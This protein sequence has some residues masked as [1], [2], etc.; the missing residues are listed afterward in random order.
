MLAVVIEKQSHQNSVYRQVKNP[1]PTFVIPKK[2]G[3]NAEKPTLPFNRKLMEKAEGFTSRFDF[4]MHVAVAR[5]LGKRFR[6]PPVLRLRAIEALLQ[7]LC[8]HY[9]PLANRANATLTTIAIECGLATESKKGNLAIT[10]ATRALQSLAKD[11]GF[12]TYSDKAFDPTIGCNLPTDITFTPAFF[13]ALDVS[14]DAV[15]AARSSRAEWK[16]KE[17]EKKGLARIGIDELISQAWQAFHKRFKE[18]RLIRKAHGEKR[19]RARRDAK[20]THQDIKALVH[21]EL[22]RELAQGLFPADRN[23]VTEEVKRR[24]RMVM[25]RGNYTRLARTAAPA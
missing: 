3:S 6:K 14:A 13:D 12:I 9:D 22:T 2:K 1:F 25:S 11:F 21:R 7:G 5:S 23:A 19:A 10:R 24:V 17:R 15:A 20:R 4:S 16:N 18:Y 8:F